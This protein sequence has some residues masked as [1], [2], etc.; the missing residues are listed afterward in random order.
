MAKSPQTEDAA[1]RR[2]DPAGPLGP[3]RSAPGKDGGQA[4]YW[5]FV[6]KK[7][8]QT[9]CRMSKHLWQLDLFGRP[10]RCDRCGLE[11]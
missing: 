6:T 3:S 11:D 5:I 8:P 7:S 4:G 10:V 1:G 9:E 2:P